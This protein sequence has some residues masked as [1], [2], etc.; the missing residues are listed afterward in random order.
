MTAASSNAAGV[1]DA[2]TLPVNTDGLTPARTKVDT[3]TVMAILPNDTDGETPASLN[4]AAVGEIV[5]PVGI[6]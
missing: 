1:G 5:T 4:D 6:V 3:A 2:V